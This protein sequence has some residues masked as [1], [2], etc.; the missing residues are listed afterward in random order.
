ME[1]SII[2]PVF[3]SVGGIAFCL[4]SLLAQTVSD[5]EIITV[6]DASTDNSLEI[7]QEYKKKNPDKIRIINL[8]N[9]IKQG[10]ARNAGI[11]YSKGRFIGFVDSD[12]W[13]APDMYEKLLQK[14][15]NTG[16]DVVCCDM[17]I[18]HH[19]DFEPGQAVKMIEDGIQG[20]LYEKQYQRLVLHSGSIVCK[21]YKREIIIENDLWFPENVFYEDNCT[22]I[23]MM[24]YATHLEKV[25]IPLYFYYMNQN[26]TTH[27]KNNERMFDRLITAELL[28]EEFKKRG[29]YNK[30]KDELLY[31]FVEL[32]YANTL[33]CYQIYF[34]KFNYSKL[35][36]MKK[37]KKDIA[38]GF[39]KNKYRKTMEKKLRILMGLND[40]SPLLYIVVVYIKRFIKSIFVK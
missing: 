2:V 15:S 28:V 31:R 24:L 38:S 26:S 27:K 13:I 6:N 39:N 1:L 3:N 20:V 12:D 25:D 10:G 21:I 9:N 33:R 18:K 40:I 4:D 23:L 7:L 36:E 37:K 32:Y 35:L 22:G 30:Y 29:F 16:A 8:E 11:R 14:A 34:K 5:Y 19:H 17:F